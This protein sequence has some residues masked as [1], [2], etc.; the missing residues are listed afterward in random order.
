[1]R[2]PDPGATVKYAKQQGNGIQEKLTTA[3]ASHFGGAVAISL[4]MVV[5]R[6]AAL[7]HYIRLM[8]RTQEDL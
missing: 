6:L 8:L 3:L 5:L 1:L 7:V 4:V 2:D